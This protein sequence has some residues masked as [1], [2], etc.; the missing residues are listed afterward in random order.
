VSNGGTG[1]A[2]SEELSHLEQVYAEV[3]A[4]VV[5]TS[6]VSINDHF[7]DDLG[8]D[9][10]VMAKF[11]ARVRKRSAV[12]SVS[13]KD[14]YRFSTVRALAA[15]LIE[16]RPD[17]EAGQ[18]SIDKS[19]SAAAWVSGARGRGTASGAETLAGMTS[20]LE[21]VESTDSSD[22]ATVPSLFRSTEVLSSPVAGEVALGTGR[23]MVVVCG[24]VQLLFF[25][26]YTWV[27][28]CVVSYD[29]EWI[30]SGGGPFDRLAHTV[31]AGAALAPVYGWVVAAAGVLGVYVRSVVAV[32]VSFLV[33]SS[34]PVAAKW[35]LV[36]RWKATEFPLWGWTY[37]RFWM[38]KTLVR[39]NPV[40]LFAGSP[41]FNLYLRALGANIGRGVLVLTPTVPVCT[42]LLSIG[43]GSVVRK[44]V[45]LS[46]YRA[47]AGV[48]Q[49]GRVSLGENVFVSESTVLDIDASMGDGSQLGHASSLHRGQS[50]PAGQ[51]WHGTPAQPCDTDFRA[52]HTAAGSTGGNVD[53]APPLEEDG[54]DVG[55]GR[56]TAS[57]PPAS[58][59]GAPTSGGHWLAWRRGVFSVGQLVSVLGV[60]LPVASGGLLMVVTVVPW[61]SAATRFE[62]GVLR[63]WGAVGRIAV[64]TG[65]AIV[66]LLSGGL[67]L[68]ALC[69]R[70]LRL[71]V[72]PGRVYRLYGPRYWAHRAISRIPTAS[73]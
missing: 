6:S 27:L 72:S 66:V 52:I 33:V 24:A 8:V 69:S 65:V 71:M 23:G 40:V 12:P 51:S 63:S 11:C 55:A 64:V 28:A 59:V 19:S 9:S 60:R 54:Q 43:A 35:V 58:G 44:D 13:M 29:V 36:G 14:I 3:L 18:P 16:H 49:T 34:L 50:V 53:I 56:P 47:H 41:L 30:Y 10:M 38:V 39:M 37:I 15:G 62:E 5:D 25:V 7:F 2:G 42:D 31:F 20:P 26:A 70:L 57:F 68:V 46:C 48:I 67:F 1:G 22:G 45:A 32:A 61:L 21:R 73:R 17:F 4:E